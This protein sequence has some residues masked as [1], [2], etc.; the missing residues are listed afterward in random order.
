MMTEDAP[1]GNYLLRK[2]FNGLRWIVRGGSSWRML[3]HAVSPWAVVHQQPQHWFKV[4]VFAAI[5]HDCELSDGS[6]LAGRTC[7]WL[8][9]STVGTAIN[10]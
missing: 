2:V 4:K 5:A 8:R 10:D 3:P 7:R 6:P 9:S 1:Q